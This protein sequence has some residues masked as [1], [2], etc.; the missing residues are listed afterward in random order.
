[1][2]FF[3]IPHKSQFSRFKTDFLDNFNDLF[4]NLVHFTEDISKEINPFLSSILITDTTGVEAYVSENNPK[5]YQSQLKKSK[6]YSKHFAKT[7]PNSGFDVEKFN[8]LILTFSFLCLFSVHKLIIL[9][10]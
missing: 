5:F 9:V 3:K 10:L 1:M 8:G 6:A 7:N 4:N 2:W